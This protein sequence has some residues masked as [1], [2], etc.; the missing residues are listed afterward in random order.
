MNIILRKINTL[1]SP[2]HRFYLELFLAMLQTQVTRAIVWYPILK[3][4]GV[5]KTSI[6]SESFILAIRF[7]NPTRIYIKINTIA[8]LL[9]KTRN[10]RVFI[11]I[12]S[13]DDHNMNETWY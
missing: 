6:S 7:Q 13:T 9:L 2:S 3:T 10:T 8:L 4:D 11:F 12:H 1:Y 5:T